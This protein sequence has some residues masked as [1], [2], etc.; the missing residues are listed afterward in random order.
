M[1]KTESTLGLV[2]SIIGAVLTFF[3]LIG[4][5]FTTFFFSYFEPVLKNLFL[6]YVPDHVLGYGLTYDSFSEWIV[7]MI[8]IFAAAAIAVAAASFIL[9]FLGA[10]K[11]NRD[12][13]SGGVLLIVGGSLALVSFIGFIPFVLM[14]VG[15]IMAVSR[16]PS[17]AAQPGIN[18]T[19]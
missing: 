11:L 12:D 6:R 10:A 16:K 13:K 1:Y 9:G 17:I 2:G 19:V 14:L 18:K 5:L 8:A 3:V 7:P 4:T 15:G